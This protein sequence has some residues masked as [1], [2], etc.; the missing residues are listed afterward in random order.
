MDKLVFVRRI[1]VADTRQFFADN[2]GVSTFRLAAFFQ[3]GIKIPQPG[4]DDTQQDK[5][6]IGQTHDRSVSL[7]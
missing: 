4:V 5:G 6:I 7:H 1:D 3:T 2:G